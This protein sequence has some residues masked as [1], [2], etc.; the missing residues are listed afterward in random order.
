MTRDHPRLIAKALLLLAFCGLAG[1]ERHSVA[2]LLEPLKL[3][4]YRSGTL[5][6]GFSGNTFDGRHVSMADL[7]GKVVI[8]N[9]WATWCA[10]CRPEMPV[11]EQL[12]R[13]FAERGLSIIAVNAR[14][15]EAA[16]GRFA[17][18]LGLT[19]PLVLDPD[20]AIGA[21]YG[22]IG[23]PATF[24]VAR[25]GRAVAFAV[26]A[27]EWGSAPARALIRALLAETTLPP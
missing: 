15:G 13:E 6:P 24:V 16:V 27:R 23:L 25:D 22:A 8:V 14:E 11:L 19:F 20:G 9:F 17:H 21:G 26:G 18:A 5:P 2:P 7:R 1:A 3:V 12:H 4:A 10:A